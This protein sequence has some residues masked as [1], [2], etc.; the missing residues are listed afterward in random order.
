MIIS[1]RWICSYYRIG[2]GPA[3]IGDRFLRARY[4]AR[5]SLSIHFVSP[6]AIRVHTTT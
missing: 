5:F 6:Y 3:D 1:I 4:S 2:S